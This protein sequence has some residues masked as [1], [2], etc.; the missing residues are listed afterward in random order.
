MKDIEMFFFNDD[1]EI[2]VDKYPFGIALEIENKSK[3]KRGENTIKYW[4]NKLNIDVG[5]HTDFLGMINIQVY[6]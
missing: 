4:A 3:V 5:K 1:I 2:V 6:A